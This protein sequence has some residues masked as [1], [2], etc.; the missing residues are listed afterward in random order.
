LLRPA[1]TVGLVVGSICFEKRCSRLA[2]CCIL[3][4]YLV[5]KHLFGLVVMG[6]VDVSTPNNRSHHNVKEMSMYQ[7]LGK[8]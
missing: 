7:S 4:Q 1:K 2:C 6:M 3:N 8:W 5:P